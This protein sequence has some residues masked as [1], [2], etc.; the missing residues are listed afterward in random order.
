LGYR[1]TWVF[2]LITAAPFDSVLRDLL[3]KIESKE[4]W[5]AS[6]DL[7][8]SK[9]F[10]SRPRTQ[11]SPESHE[12]LQAMSKLNPRLDRDPYQLCDYGAP[13]SPPRGMDS[14]FGSFESKAEPP[15]V[16]PLN[17]QR[18]RATQPPAYAFL[19]PSSLISGVVLIILQ[20]TQGK[21]THAYQP[22]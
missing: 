14:M 21:W 13:G 8:Q 15:R 10:G 6:R 12:H 1:R 22:R 17:P 16:V 19:L 7:Q 9:P 20:W 18:S 5:C 3:R 2:G 11:I 4:F